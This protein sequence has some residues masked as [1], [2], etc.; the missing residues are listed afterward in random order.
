[1]IIKTA[2]LIVDDREENLL[3]LERILAHTDVMIVKAQNGNDA[4]KACINH[5]FALALLDVNMP[6]MNGYE[7]AGLMRGEKS[8]SAT[9]I[10]FLTAAYTH[11][12]QIFKGY[13][14]G[15]VDY[16][17]KPIN[18]EILLNKVNVFLDIYRQKQEL[19]QLN[20]QYL[21]ARQEAESATRV[22]SAFLANMSHE[23]RSPMNGILGMT[24]L[25]LSDN[26]T[27]EQ[28]RYA[29]IVLENG[30][31][32]LALLNDILDLSK[33]EADMIELED[34][35]FTLEDTL[36]F[37]T[38]ILGFSAREKGLEL[39]THIELGVPSILRGDPLRLRQIIINLMGNSVKYTEQGRV[40]IR[41]SVQ[42]EESNSLCLRFDIKDTGIGISECCLTEIFKPFTQ[43]DSSTTRRYGGTGL[44]LST[45][46]SIVKD[47]LG[48][49]LVNSQMGNGSTF[50]L[51][52]PER[53][54]S[55]EEDK[56][57][58]NIIG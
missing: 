5:D 9:P 54:P 27:S 24:Q 40:V 26:L 49:I 57:G 28:Q 50:T 21:L 55:T 31:H 53:T 20:K 38:D 3:A 46:H 2:I 14:A 36:R 43:A 33:I 10:I 19:I 51:F 45:V 23:I 30:N 44:G 34:I 35:D 37:A 8:H 17:V 15:A 29:E 4:L 18:N 41:V 16:M 52:F 1:M 7:L 56:N 12:E 13:S 22:K 48:E 32:L 47:H 39:I 58:Q 6:D 25:L 11:D 42:S